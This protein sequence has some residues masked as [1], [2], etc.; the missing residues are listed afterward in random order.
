MNDILT[1]NNVRGYLNKETG[2]AYLNAEDVA[3][4]FGFTTR[5]NI[6]G[7]EYDNVRW[8]TVNKYLS[9]FGFFATSCKKV[10]KDDFLPENMVY[11]LGFKASNETAQRFQ[12]KLADEVLPAIR[13]TGGYISGS[14]TMTDSEIMA[15]ALM[16]AQKTIENRKQR[17]QH[18][19]AETARMQ[20]KEVFADAVCASKTSILIGD[21]AKILKQNGFQTGQKRLFQQLRDEGY[22]IKAGSSRNMPTQRAMELGLFE[23]K[24]TNISNP[25]GSIRTTKTTK[26]TGKGQIYFI[27]KYLGGKDNQ[28]GPIT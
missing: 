22:L 13:K 5:Q 19:E 28:G 25:D 3:R 17:I 23:V 26:V 18:L 24:E 21:L 15:K 14:E 4:G 1:I 6:N 20:P 16:V 27:K 2:V 11:R 7:V 8:N 10:G 9:E 12:A